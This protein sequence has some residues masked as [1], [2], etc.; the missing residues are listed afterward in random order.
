MN[1]NASKQKLIIIL[2][3]LKGGGAERVAAYLANYWAE[4]HKFEIE[5]VLLQATGELITILNPLIKVTDLNCTRIRDSIFQLSKLIKEKKPTIIWVGLWPLTISSIISWL[6]AGRPGKFYVT[7]HITHSGTPDFRK[8]LKRLAIKLSMQI[9]YPFTNG[10]IGVSEGVTEDIRKFIKFFQPRIETLNNPVKIN[11]NPVKNI[12]ATEWPLNDSFKILSVGT[13]KR[14]KNYKLLI[15][16][17]SI[18]ASRVNAQLVIL[19]EGEMRK[20]LENY[21]STLGIDSRVFLPG[22]TLNTDSWFSTCDAF[23]LSSDWEGLPT[24]LI[25]ALMHKCNIVSTDCPSGPMEILDNGEFG[26]LVP[27]ESPTALAEAILEIIK[28]PFEKNKFD[29][30]IKQFTVENVS[31][32]YYNFFFIEN[33]Q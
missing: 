6:I 23:V 33:N 12:D 20:E 16:A 11:E 26:I 5:F 8:I 9:C 2:P 22:F 27:R 14:Q 19:G 4:K 18:V 32:K 3:N 13:L 24:V 31:N 17:F 28:N 30:K 1:L 21:I 29:N 15:K 25:E 10:I 7:E